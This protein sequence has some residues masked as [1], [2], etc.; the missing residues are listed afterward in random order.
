MVEVSL[1]S[2]FCASNPSKLSTRLHQVIELPSRRDSQFLLSCTVSPV[3]VL[4]ASIRSCRCYSFWVKAEAN[5]IWYSYREYYL[6]ACT[7]S[8]ELSKKIVLV[9]VSSQSKTNSMV[10]FS[11][12]PLL[13]AAVFISRA[14]RPAASAAVKS[15]PSAAVRCRRHHGHASTPS[16]PSATSA[17]NRPLRPQAGLY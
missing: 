12:T 2:V 8:C 17:G 15:L 10:G 13:R 5:C 16:R 11:Y 6:E 3:Q 1:R 7:C 9:Y 4:G 14:L